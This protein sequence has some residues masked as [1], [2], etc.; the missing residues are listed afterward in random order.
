[1]FNGLGNQALYAAFRITSHFRL[2]DTSDVLTKMGTAF[3]VTN[4]RGKNCIVTNRHILDAGYNEPAGKYLGAVLH[5]VLVEG[6][7]AAEG[8]VMSL[9]V[10]P[11][12]LEVMVQ[13]SALSFPPDY[14]EDV[15]CFIDPKVIVRHGGDASIHFFLKHEE[16]ADDAWIESQL[17]VCDF[18]AFPGF[19]P[20]HDKLALRPILRT[21]TIS[22]DPRT[23]YSDE[24]IAKGRRVAYEAFSFGGSSGS[25]IFATQKGFQATGGITVTGFREAKVVGINAGHLEGDFGAHSGVSYFIKSSAILNLIDAGG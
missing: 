24:R 11:I 15:A 16:L 4:L 22:S 8:G 13:S 20:W 12:S 23:N 5:S 6:F 25:P 19:P 9:P 14:F 10:A 18:V 3:F 2:R 17:S 1:M 7:S 21:G